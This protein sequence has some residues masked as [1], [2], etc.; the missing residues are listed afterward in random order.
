MATKISLT[1]NK[2]GFSECMYA[3]CS[4]AEMLVKKEIKKKVRREYYIVFY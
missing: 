4:A 2:T 3:V 1:R